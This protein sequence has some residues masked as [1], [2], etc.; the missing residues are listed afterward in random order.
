[1][2]GMDTWDYAKG[3]YHYIEYNRSGP[4]VGRTM[5]MILTKGY[6]MK[7]ACNDLFMVII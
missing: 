7:R 6:I 4:M 5:S 2:I 1:M 3:V